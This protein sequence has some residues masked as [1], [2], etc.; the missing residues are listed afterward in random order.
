MPR[1]ATGTVIWAGDHWRARIR[2]TDGSRPW[3]D[4]PTGLTEAQARKKAMD[5]TTRAREI[6]A[7]KDTPG[8]GIP[9]AVEGI[10]AWSLRFLQD[11]RRRGLTSVRNDEGRLRTH[12]LPFFG[13]QTPVRA[14]TRERVEALVERL[15]RQTHAGEL[16]WKTALNI[17]TLICAMFREA[18][19]S[20]TRALRVRE[21]NPCLNVRP[22]DRGVRK[23]KAYLFPS[24][25][26]RLVECEAV[27]LAW[28]RL[29]TIAV[30]LA[31]RAG[32]L[33]ALRWED[34]D[35]E[36]GVVHIHR[37]FDRVTAREKQTKGEEARR[38]AFEPALRPLLERM[39]EEAHG[40][41]VFEEFPRENQFAIQLRRHLQTA[42]VTRAEL[43]TTDDTRKQ[44]TFHDLRAT[45]VTW[46]AVRGDEPL[47]IRHRAG[48]KGF[49][50]TEGY[51]REAIAVQERFG[52]PFPELPT[53][54]LAD[55]AVVPPNGPTNGPP[56][57]TKPPE[58]VR[59][60]GLTRVRGGGLEPAPGVGY[61]RFPRG[62]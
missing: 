6:G 33:Q 23:A 4:L 51:I 49:A 26:L 12:I 57:K 35:L 62:F 46:M 36:H 40:E 21:D 53:I 58:P 50:T 42:G 61:R 39:R 45:G 27:P 25:F 54:L 5:L 60:R 44:L 31:A 2:L 30:Y 20:K 17:W 28:R 24:E 37:A 47:K 48:H 1:K 15:D 19:G 59:F 13:P 41:R 18:S 34:V 52:I 8:A 16:G 38:F 14:I 29:V 56:E 10:E 43:F 22:P 32:E 55:T 7:T 11:R 3:I 9:D